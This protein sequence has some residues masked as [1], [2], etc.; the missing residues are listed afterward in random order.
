MTIT[1]NAARKTLRQMAPQLGSQTRRHSPV[2]K[3]SNSLPAFAGEAEQHRGD[4]QAGEVG[5][6]QAARPAR[7]A[8]PGDDVIVDLHVER[9]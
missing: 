5:I 2:I 7:L 8:P 6:G 1:Q 4:G 9:G 3:V